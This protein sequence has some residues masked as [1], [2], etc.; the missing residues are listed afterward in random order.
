MHR[1][2]WK[3]SAPFR[4]ASPAHMKNRRECELDCPALWPFIYLC[5]QMDW[6]SGVGLLG[7]WKRKRS[8]RE[9]QHEWVGVWNRAV[10]AAC[11][12]PQKHLSSPC[13][14]PAHTWKKRRRP[15]LLRAIDWLRLKVGLKSLGG[16]YGALLPLGRCLG[17]LVIEVAAK[18]QIHSCD[19]LVTTNFWGV[20]AL[21]V[22]GLAQSRVGVTGSPLPDYWAA[23][24]V[25]ANWVARFLNENSLSCI[26]PTFCV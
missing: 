20:E 19:K 23:L 22:F 7:E 16:S 14:Y 18:S 21:W 26:S 2:L 5:K 24:S 1:I 8:R 12:D 3:Y 10:L 11:W 4:P 13:L 6:E 25:S 15:G 17:I 9:L